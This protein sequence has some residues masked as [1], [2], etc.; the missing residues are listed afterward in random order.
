MADTTLD[1]GNLTLNSEEARDTSDIIFKEAFLSPEIEMIHDIQTDVD[2]DKFIPIFG[3]MGLTG[4]AHA[5]SCERNAEDATIPVSQKQWTPKLISG[6]LTVCADDLPALFKAWRRNSP[7]RDSWENINDEYMAFI[8]E[9]TLESIKLSV[10]RHAEFGNT[11]A[12][13]IGD[14]TGDQTL[15]VGI[16]KTYFNV[17]DGMWQQ[18]EAD[19]ALAPN[20]LGYRATIAEN[21]LASKA[22]QLAL[23]NTTAL[24][25]MRDIY[26]N[27][28]PEAFEGQKL[29]FQITRSLF[30]NW[31][32]FL[33]D[34][35]LVFT[36]T[37]AETKGVTDKYT[38]RGIPIEVR[39]DWDRTIRAYYDNGTTYHLPH[40][41]L[42]SDNSNIPVGTRDS[43]SLSSFSSKFIDNGVSEKHYIKYAYN[44]DCKVLEED[45]L[46]YGF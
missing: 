16:D 41:I 7:T 33:E 36:L 12:S 39:Y 30:N 44:I 45:K 8:E 1:W 15:T 43:E 31:M 46:A 5:G 27:I 14:A 20:N 9:R 18:L 2:M 3:R 42:L 21:A 6:N 28:A 38:Y 10:I 4:K 11:N 34:K 25:T 19:A 17:I 24:D 13:P 32:A 40:R 35:S 23:G 22:L 37:Q 29:K 26:E